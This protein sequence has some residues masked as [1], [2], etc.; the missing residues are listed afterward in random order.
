MVVGGGENVPGQPAGELRKGERK[1][2][3][4]RG[5]TGCH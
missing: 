1:G 2:E 5:A 4:E 3:S